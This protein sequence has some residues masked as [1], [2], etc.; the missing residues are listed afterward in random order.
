MHEVD[1][2]FII[3]DLLESISHVVLQQDWLEVELYLTRH[4]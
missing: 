2:N 4:A 3:Y 1:F